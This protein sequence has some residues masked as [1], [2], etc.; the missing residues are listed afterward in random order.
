MKIYKVIVDKEISYN[1]AGDGI[2]NYTED[3][4]TEIYATRKN[5]NTGFDSCYTVARINM[6]KVIG[7]FELT[8]EELEKDGFLPWEVK[9]LLENK[10]E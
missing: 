10:N 2:D 5:R 3:G 9:R 6:S 1:V 7:I 4:I 8:S